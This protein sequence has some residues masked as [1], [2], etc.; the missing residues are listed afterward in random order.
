MATLS[1]IETNYYYQ[2]VLGWER[3]MNYFLQEN[4][5]LKTRLAQA[6]EVEMNKERLELAE[7]FQNCFLQHDGKIKKLKNEIDLIARSMKDLIR[8]TEK[9]ELPGEYQQL[10]KKIKDL[11]RSFDETRSAFN[12]YLLSFVKI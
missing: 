4:A 12:N 7:Q 1:N 3:A 10:D 11:T 5:F 2:E 8:N 9:K 6:A